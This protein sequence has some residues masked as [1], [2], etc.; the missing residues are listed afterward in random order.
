[1]TLCLVASAATVTASLFDSCAYICHRLPN[2]ILYH[3]LGSTS[4]D[5]AIMAE[6]IIRVYFDSFIRANRFVRVEC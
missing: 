4:L 6:K 3:R 2:V 5:V 1:V